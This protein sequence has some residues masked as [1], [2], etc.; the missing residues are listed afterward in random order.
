MAI[1]LCL[2]A[3]LL[4]LSVLLLAIPLEM[5]L[6]Y[7][8]EGE[9]DLLGLDLLVWPSLGFRIRVFML[10]FKTGLGKSVLFYRTGPEESGGAGAGRKKIMVPDAREMADQFFFWK[11]VYSRIGPAVSYFKSR[12]KITGLT[13]KTTF[14][15]GD[16]FYTGMAAGMIWSVKGLAISALYSHLKAVK[17]PVLAVVP[18]FSR[19]CLA[20]RLDFS[21]STRSGYVVI[22]AL[23]I[24]ASM[25]FS[26]RA[27]DALWMIR[28]MRR[29]ISGSLK[30]RE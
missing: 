7:G 25:L 3:G 22:A 26:G 23:R 15:L 8:R 19:A 20:M 21:L 17:K 14:G 9:R 30:S 28:R 11:G 29:N 2:L 6:R 10:D 18:D 1:T 27:R 5:R 13:W 24:L 4:I 16:P 12:L